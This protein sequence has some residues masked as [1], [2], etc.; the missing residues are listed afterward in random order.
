[1]GIKYYLGALIFL[2][3]GAVSAA[4]DAGVDGRAA[5][6]F[7]S[8]MSPFCDAQTLSDCGNEQTRAVRNR[9]RELL[10][11]GSSDNEIRDELISTYG[12]EITGMPT[13]AI[14]RY[15][16]WIVPLAFLLFCAAA[17]VFSAN[18][19]PASLT[20][21]MT[22]DESRRLLEEEL[23]ARARINN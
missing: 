5:R 1:M 22:A 19:T 13:G 4:A 3:L 14:G 10:A 23:A 16:G 20:T 18:R 11:Q 17:A 9:V 8:L 15:L 2:G 7:G 12:E 6:I 21:S